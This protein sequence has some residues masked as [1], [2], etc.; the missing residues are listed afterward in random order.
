MS[1]V[2]IV[3]NDAQ[4][5]PRA[6]RSVLDQTLGNLELIIADDC[7]TDGTEQVAR[8]LESTDPRVR[9][10]R[11]ERN[12]GGCS[13]PR[14]R[15]IEAAR[16]PHVMF[17][18]S[19]DELPRHSCKSLL[20]V[21]EETGADFVTGA[22]TRYY[23]ESGTVG[24][25]Y[26]NLFTEQRLV[27][28]I[29]E[30]PEYFFDHLSTNKLYRTAFI[31]DHAL[32]F[33]EGIHYED[34]LFSAQAFTLAESF[35]VVPWPVYTWRLAPASA[36]ISSSRHK[37]QNVCDRIHV[38][39]LIDSYLDE[40]GHAEL[41]DAKDYKFLRHDFRLYLGDLPF[42]DARWLAEFA[43]AVTPYLS[44]IAPGTYARLSREE[45]VC[46]HLLRTGRLSELAVA[47]RQ[48]GHPRVAPRYATE[49]GE[50]TYWG[51]G[52]PAGAEARDELDISEWCL[53]DQEFGSARIRHELVSLQ[54]RGT[55]LRMEIRTYDPAG[56]I[57]EG[58]TA[59]LDLTAYG[60][61]LTVPFTMAPEGEGQ[62]VATV[63]VDLRKIPVGR[64]GVSTR[65]HPVVSVEKDGVHRFDLLLAPHDL[66]EHRT[67]VSYGRLGA[68]RVTVRP[69]QRGAGRLEVVW[70]R[71]GVLRTLEP[72]GPRVRKAKKKVNGVK[73]VL[74]GNEGKATVY[75]LVSKLPRKRQLAVFEA[76]EGRGYAD[77]PRYIYEEL[78]RR[79]L[80]I[81]VVWSHS[82]DTSSFPD[83]VTLVRRGS[84]AYGRALARARYWVDS[85]N[86]P[87]L[88][89]KPKGTKYL[90]TWHGQ[91]LKAMGFDMPSHRTAPADTQERFRAAVG[92]WDALVCPSAEFERTFVPAFEVRADLIHSGYPR[93]DALVRWDEP[94]QQTRAQATRAA[95]EIPDGKKVLLYAPTYRDAA[96]GTGR[97]IR[98]DLAELAESV[99]DDWV[100]VVR[101]HPYDRFEVAPELVRFL[102]DGS[103]FADINDVMLASDAV[104]TDYSSLMFDY[105]NTGRPIL[106]YTDDYEDYRRGERRPY[107][108]LAEIAP[109]PMLTTTGELAAAMADIDGVADRHAERYEHFRQLFCLYET[110]HASKLVVDAFFEGGTHG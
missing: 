79:D 46:I 85:H 103:P 82:G 100:V 45:R 41:R 70:E 61:P 95:L 31:R 19:D 59:S 92:R 26:P 48:L 75:D 1:V 80:P 52:V 98:V 107:Y 7:S 35:A 66:P 63:D 89:G 37:I 16:A 9:Y 88:Y 64:A 90:Q 20:L 12:S 32:T 39:R 67:G 53:R 71:S 40:H 43:E 87:Y 105:A 17:L 62:Y 84:W 24:S 73:K 96:R 57:G 29:G 102:R 25:W 69:E 108:D 76:H 34:Q 33:P 13:A 91:T 11:L 97:S 14:N 27:Q 51:A 109:G 104:L 49:D 78:R 8:E 99:G 42:R 58:V 28:G 4:R 81:D 94:A 23:E 50:H 3:Y 56:L 36:S 5:L 106:L 83:D 86:L 38:A 72:L 93:N 21:A 30:Q 2:L 110:G 68:H 6:V 47:A 60:K 74:V 101:A 22:V 18:D 54:P 55:V 77:N 44:R 65:R 10:L 15:G